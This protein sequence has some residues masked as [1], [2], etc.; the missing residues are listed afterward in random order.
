ML[1]SSLQKW[2][3]G[4]VH[5]H[6]EGSKLKSKANWSWNRGQGTSF[7]NSHSSRA[8]K[9]TPPSHL[10][11]DNKPR[12]RGFSPHSRESAPPGSSALLSPSALE[13]L[14]RF[15]FFPGQ[16]N[17]KDEVYPSSVGLKGAG[18]GRWE[19]LE[20]ARKG[21]KAFPRGWRVRPT[22]AALSTVEENGPQPP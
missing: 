16:F 21:A 15:F 9:R 17:A 7:C 8:T 19:N 22:Q 20:E 13:A 3:S 18:E 6:G 5:T 12:A 11:Y 2:R 1:R 14:Q 4:L 10:L